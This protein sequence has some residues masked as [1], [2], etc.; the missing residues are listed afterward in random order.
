MPRKP[1]HTDRRPLLS[2]IRSI[3]ALTASAPS[4]AS[5][6]PT[7][8]P[9]ANTDAPTADQP[10]S[11][12]QPPAGD[13]PDQLLRLDGSATLSLT[14]EFTRAN[15]EPA[16]TAPDTAAPAEPVRFRLLAYS[17][18]IMYP[19]LRGIDWT[20]PVVVDTGGL[21]APYQM[22]V[23]RE[24]DRLKPVG[25][26]SIEITDGRVYASGLF[27]VDS[28]DSR[29]IIDS[30]AKGFPWAASI[31][32]GNMTAERVPAGR[33]VTVNGSDFAG[34][35]LVIRRGDLNEVSIVTIGGD[36]NTY[37][38]V[39]AAQSP[40]V[41]AVN[42]EQWVASLGLVVAN[43][44]AAAVDQL[45][46]SF[47]ALQAAP[48]SAGQATATA[49]A[50]SAT[51]SAPAPAAPSAT[52][53]APASV[54]TIDLGASLNAARL[55]AASEDERIANIRD[56]GARY[57]S[58]RLAD[59]SLL[60][61]HAITQGWSADRTELEATRVSRPASPAIH[62]TGADQRRT[63]ET[64]QAGFMLRAGRSIDTVLREPGT[65]APE[66]TRLGVNDP[67]RQ[68]I[69]NNAYEF[70]DLHLMEMVAESLRACGHSVPSGRNH[71]AI[72]QAGF[73]T[74]SIQSVFSQSIGA[75]ALMAYAEGDDF[76]LGWISERDVPNLLET[77][78]PRMIAGQD[79]TRHPT[80]AEADHASRE[81]KNEKVQAD[82][83]SRQT[84]VDEVHFINDQFGLIA[85]T[86]RDFGAA[87]RRLVPNMVAAVLLANEN[88][89]ATG[90]ALFNT[91]DVSLIASSALSQANLSKARAAL[92]K[93]KD[94]DASLNLQATHLI[95][96]SELG[97]LAIQLTG[98]A[99]ISADSGQGSMNPIR[100]R[101]I[102]PRDEGRLS[103]GVVSP[104]TGATLAGSLT[105]WY[106][107][108]NQ[109]HTI[110]V[111]YLQG[112]GR[113]P[114]VTVEQLTG[115]KLG[116][117]VVVKHYVG[118]KA[119]DFRGMVRCDA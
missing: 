79:L 106:L 83:Y 109:A 112:T 103:N 29:E 57:N 107:V 66:W 97:D 77:D 21:I 20:G 13:Q 84:Q 26:G 76:S 48:Q 46:A 118:A 100:M 68:R 12:T 28:D 40:G 74:H 50:P 30:A 49:S 61:A 1:R 62:S 35:I 52:A 64:L 114:V 86:P 11:A 60:T 91:T 51:A 99:V 101:N 119:L 111:Q 3:L 82:R 65:V 69:M 105:S 88:L 117:C 108:S 113:Q 32:L 71:H 75:V 8:T 81:A 78:R 89:A 37:A 41:S 93:R 38:A 67:V 6:S 80:D 17:G 14:A 34:P 39:Y 7:A 19:N 22:P 15:L 47:A 96:P 27:S 36:P 90:R 24:H 56:I 72:L 59:G 43:L 23:H 58:P 115:G 42:F 54:A 92:S 5:T 31:G 95:T 4:T 9:T 2:G 18:G 73:S 45:R 104:K 33:N 10:P 53:A 63:V 25:H 44:S 16:T 98:S 110:E 87:A 116:L 55:A 70:R 94:G 85:E 102:Q